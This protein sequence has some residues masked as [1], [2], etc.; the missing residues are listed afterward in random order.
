MSGGILIKV[1]HG[2]SGFNDPL[3]CNTAA[4]TG[5]QMSYGFKQVWQNH[6]G[7]P[8]NC[9]CEQLHVSVPCGGGASVQTDT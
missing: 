4:N 9:M 6:E 5:L 2:K 3:F 8:C 1:L 7:T